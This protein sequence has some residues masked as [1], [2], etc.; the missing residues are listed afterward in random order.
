MSITIAIPTRDR[1]AY[2][3]VLLSSLAFQSLNNFKVILLPNGDSSDQMKAP[4]VRKLVD[5]MRAKGISVRE[6]FL[7][8]IGKNASAA[9]NRATVECDTELLLCLDD[10]M[11][12]PPDYLDT[13]AASFLEAERRF[14][15]NPIVMCGLTPWM[16]SPWEGV[17]PNEVRC[18][19]DKEGKVIE[20]VDHGEPVDGGGSDFSILAR[21]NV[22]YLVVDKEDHIRKSDVISPA[23]FLMRPDPTVPWATVGEYATFGDIAW[24]ILAKRAGYEILFDMRCH[25]WHVNANDGGTRKKEDCYIKDGD[26]IAAQRKRIVKLLR[27]R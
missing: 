20:V 4:I 3:A 24:S 23:N 8:Q 5:F 27:K 7:G 17:G 6:I 18:P 11:L 13:L 16:E 25:A 26:G 12:L 10:D 2:L 15:D 19:L 14:P 1:P 22:I 21:Q 9:F